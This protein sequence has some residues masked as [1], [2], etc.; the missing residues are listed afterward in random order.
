MPINF[1]ATAGRPAI[2][3]AALAFNKHIADELTSRMTGNPDLIPGSPEQEAI[4]DF[5][6]RGT[7]H[8]VVRA[9]A[10]TGKTFT[11]IQGVLRMTRESAV[12]FTALTY[13]SF[14]WR[15]CRRAYR[16]VE[17]DAAKMNRIVDA[18]TEDRYGR[19][20]LG[21]MAWTEV[22][23]AVRRLVSLCMNTLDDGTNS[24]RLSDLA[25]TH[26]VIISDA[27]S[28][29]VYDLVP[30]V[31]K[32]TAD[33]T[34]TMSFDDQVWQTVTKRLPC[35][36]YD[37]LLVDEAQDTNLA[38][39]QMAMMACPTG[40]IIILGDVAQAIYGFR[41]ADVTAIPRMED[42]LRETPRGVSVFPLTVTRR[43]PKS[44]VA[45]AQG[46]VPEIRALDDAADG[47]VTTQ[48]QDDAV[49]SMRPGDLVICRTNGPLVPVCYALIRAGKKAIISGRDIGSNLRQLVDKLKAG[50]SIPNL[51]Q[52]LDE[53]RTKEVTKLARLKERGAAK[54]Q[55]LSDRCECVEA[56][57]DGVNSVSALKAKIDRIFADFDDAGKPKDAV[58]LG[59]VHRTKGLEAHVVYV[60]A[61]ELIPHPMAKQ[62][63]EQEQERNLAYVAVTRAKFDESHPGTVRFVLSAKTIK[64][65][66]GVPAIYFGK[67]PSKVR[68][69]FGIGI[70]EQV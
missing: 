35:D 18:E 64:L 40:R 15:A 50:E 48:S 17:L 39:Q 34:A 52:K 41:G 12:D 29:F 26:N 31:L 47:I 3:V 33:D 1:S 20:N 58:I 16:N 44:H 70:E 14:G 53:Y 24:D 19:D 45:L 67:E 51:L 32:M 27:N 13:N 25:D 42:A 5:M 66:V 61:P 68:S 2:R 23:G 46:I 43:C 21:W 69:E 38:Q 6:L 4:W 28:G 57:C 7:S 63:W 11:I 9:C 30:R 55:A 37:I 22:T 8:G 10:G 59:S 65:G 36:T 62:P 60:L 54:V 49:R 56:L